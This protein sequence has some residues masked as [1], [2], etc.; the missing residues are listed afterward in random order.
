[1]QICFRNYAPSTPT[2]WPSTSGPTAPCCSLGPWSW[3]TSGPTPGTNCHLL[4]GGG[5]PQ[6]VH[7][8][9]LQR[10]RRRLRCPSHGGGS[11]KTNR[12]LLVLPPPVEKGVEATNSRRGRRVNAEVSLARSGLSTTLYSECSKDCSNSCGASHF[13]VLP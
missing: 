4:F 9:S 6:V 10:V 2:G 11:A 12:S 5:Q 8:V 3:T 7:R 1:M 13:L